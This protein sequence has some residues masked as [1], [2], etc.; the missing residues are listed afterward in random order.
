[1][2]N[3]PTPETTFAPQNPF[4]PRNPDATPF[5]SG[6]PFVSEALGAGLAQLLKPTPEVWLELARRHGLSCGFYRGGIIFS[7]VHGDPEWPGFLKGW[8]FWSGA[9]EEVFAYIRKHE[10]WLDGVLEGDYKTAGRD[11][12]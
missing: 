10:I 7:E 8:L 3:E 1:M 4:A 11:G 6:W 9:R 5:Q 12:D 2:P